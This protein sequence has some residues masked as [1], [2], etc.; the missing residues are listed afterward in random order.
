MRCRY[1]FD[2]NLPFL[3]VENTCSCKGTS[4]TVHLHCLLRWIIF[5][6]QGM[7]GV[8]KDVFLLPYAVVDAAEICFAAMETVSSL[9][10]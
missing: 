3:L 7:C 8:C 1:C 2:D 5:S 6:S 9:L 4:G 10:K